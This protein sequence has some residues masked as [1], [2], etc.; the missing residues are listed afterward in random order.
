LVFFV[1]KSIKKLNFVKNILSRKT[2]FA[3][4]VLKII[5]KY[6]ICE[7]NF[8]LILCALENTFGKLTIE[9]YFKQFNKENFS[10]NHVY[11]K[12]LLSRKK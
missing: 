2:K 6:F 4:A 5:L 10:G 9:N 8:K 11:Q 7:T 12:F 3:S 1:N